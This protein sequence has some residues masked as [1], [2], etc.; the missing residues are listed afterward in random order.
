MFARRFDKAAVAAVRTTARADRAVHLRGFVGPDDDFAAI[1][2]LTRIG[3][4]GRV[5]TDIGATR[6]R[7]RWI[8]ALVIAA[9]EH[10][11]AT[12]SA[13][14][15]DMR[16]VDEADLGAKQFDRAACSS[17]ATHREE[18]I[19]EHCTRLGPQADFAAVPAIGCDFRRCTEVDVIAGAQDDAPAILGQARRFQHAG[20]VDDAARDG[21]R[22]RR[23]QQDG[24]ALGADRLAVVDQRIERIGAHAQADQPVTGEIERDALAAAQ[25]NGALRR[26]ER[27][28]VGDLRRN[29][30][31]VAARRGADR[32]E[33]FNGAAGAAERVLA[34]QE[35]VVADVER[36][37]DQCRDIDPR[38][39]AEQYAVR[40]DQEHLAVRRQLPFNARDRRA[41]DAIEGDGGLVGL[42]K[43]DLCLAADY[44]ALPIDDCTLAALSNVHA[45][46]ARS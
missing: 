5:G 18:T 36:R 45:R 30:G 21:L 14:R 17:V 42:G 4:D 7:N 20:L 12:R 8:A 31:E 38:T 13:G 19:G 46:A 9:D 10:G 11:A 40:V 41:T 25:C 32:A 29:E 6:I 23:G 37:G 22:A 24:A 33:I 15:V 26:A 1:A 44:E 28:A 2:V 35:I 27:A 16:H 3:D 43:V 39:A 34:G